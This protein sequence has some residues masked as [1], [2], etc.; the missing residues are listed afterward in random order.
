M[1]SLEQVLES[2]DKRAARQRALLA[3][4]PGSV[5]ICLTV[6]LP[7][8]EKRN[9]RSLLIGGAALSALLNTFGSILTHVQVKDL[10]TGFEA[11]IVLPLDPLVTK[12]LCCR[13][14][15]THPL[16][17]LMDIDVL[18]GEGRIL[19]RSDAGLPPRKCLLCDNEVRLCM[20]SGNH[21][22]EEL[23]ARIDAMLADYI[24][25]HG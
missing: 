5:L 3:E 23:L 15:D 11:Y 14:E 1:T 20:R 17:R 24:G 12:Q 18:Y 16:G 2:R 6:Q 21:T 25:E 10:E 9:A 8:P 4:W 22:R 19:G 13:I 7:G